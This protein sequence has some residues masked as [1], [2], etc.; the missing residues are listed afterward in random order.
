MIFSGSTGAVVRYSA[1]ALQL[2]NSIIESQ[3]SVQYYIIYI[4]IYIINIEVFLGSRNDLFE[5]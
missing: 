2:L 4:F 1:T 3:N 5:V